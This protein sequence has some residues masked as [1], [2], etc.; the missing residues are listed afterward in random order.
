MY[1]SSYIPVFKWTR[2]KRVVT[3]D[4]FLCDWALKSWERCYLVRGWS[5]V[6]AYSRWIEL[7]KVISTNDAEMKRCEELKLS[8]LLVHSWAK[9]LWCFTLIAKQAEWL[10]WR[11]FGVRL[12]K[13]SKWMND[14][15]DANT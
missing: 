9:A 8:M 4:G 15:C 14:V 3:E 13:L 12:F 5:R 10:Q 2:S 1:Q 11:D 6:T 7:I